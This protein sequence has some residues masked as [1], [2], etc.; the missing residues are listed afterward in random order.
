MTLLQLQYFQEL[1]RELHYTRTAGELH[2]SQPSLSYAINELEKELGV[3]LF[4]RDGR[5]VIL[6]VYGQQFL[7][8]VENA[9]SLVREGTE[10]VRQMVTNAPQIVRLGYFHSI[11][12]SFI[13]S[14]VDGFYRREEER[15]IQFQFIESP[16]YEVL[17]QIRSRNLDLGFCL[18]RAEWAE[19]AGVIR[20][21]LYLA[22]PSGHPLALR[23]HVS[24]L[25]FAREP[26]IVLE[27]SSNLRHNMDQ[28]FSRHGVIPDIVF[29]VKEC[30]AA[31]QYVSLGFGVSV[32]PQVPAM[33]S[34][35]VVI[36]PISDQ[37]KE[38]VRTV[39][40]TYH[41]S[42]P[43][44]PAV[45]RVRDYIIENFALDSGGGWK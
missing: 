44:T 1:A 17:S 26:Q 35:K 32:L 39:Y 45:R 33:D 8:Y 14:L 2:I 34:D 18:H 37:D 21:P 10:T 5:K 41:K 13:P 23:S 40:L 16:S 4:Q 9:L 25:D 12:A 42:C 22:V 19:A 38:F 11:S 6:T 15:K 36:L 28:V 20:Q 24:F 43:L 27:Q 30:N 31:L 3:K 7:P 29:E